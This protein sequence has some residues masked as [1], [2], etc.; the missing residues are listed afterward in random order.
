MINIQN[1]SNFDSLPDKQSIINWAKIA[2]D[3]KNKEAEIVIRIV[4]NKEGQALNKKWCKKDYPTNVLSFPITEKIKEAPN[5]LGDIVICANVVF[6]EAKKQKK[7]INEHF[8][9][10]VIHGILHLQGYDHITDTEKN[11]MEKK[12]IAI[13]D[14]LGYRNPYVIYNQ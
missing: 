14:R 7:S 13:L 8:A 1:I 9:H 5:I 10:M 12:E 2:L 11:V 6:E 3:K 4:E